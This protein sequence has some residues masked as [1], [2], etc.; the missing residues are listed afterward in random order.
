MWSEGGTLDK[1]KN[2]VMERIYDNA[3]VFCF[4]FHCDL[5]SVFYDRFRD[6]FSNNYFKHRLLQNYKPDL[7]QI[8]FV[9]PSGVLDYSL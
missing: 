3:D 4:V 2:C 9:D 7:A 5:F 8:W 6:I 1:S